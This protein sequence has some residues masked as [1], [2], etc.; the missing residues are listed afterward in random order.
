MASQKLQVERA[1]YVIPSDTVNIPSPESL[2][3]S[4]LASATTTNKLVDAAAEFDGDQLVPIG[5]VIYNTTTQYTAKVTAVDNA[6]QLTIDTDIMSIG[7]SYKIYSK[8]SNDCML[9]IG[10]S[11]DVNVVTSG[12]DSVVYKNVAVGFMPV[13]IK[14]VLSTGTTATDIIANW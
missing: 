5:S 11:G 12:T 13:H 14:K 7:D 6:T 4:S 1:L 10:V 8:E 3:I 9:Y 2:I